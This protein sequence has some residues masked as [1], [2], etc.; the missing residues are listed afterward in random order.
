MLNNNAYI[1]DCIKSF[2]NT[3]CHIGF[4]FFFCFNEFYNFI[5]Y[6]LNELQINKL[7]LHC[8]FLFLKH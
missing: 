3:L 8:F 4:F 2:K 1:S 7:F 6:D 5:K